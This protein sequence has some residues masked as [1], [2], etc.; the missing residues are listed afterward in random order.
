MSKKIFRVILLVSVITLVASM[1]LFMGAVYGYF[2]EETKAQL[3]NDAV[4]IA[5]AVEQGGDNYLDNLPYTETRVTLVDEDGTVLFDN[6]TDAETMENHEEREEI[7]DALRKGTGESYRISDTIS[8][9]T[10]YYAIKLEDGRVLRVATS[11]YTVGAM[12]IGVLQ[13]VILILILAIVLSLV[14]ASRLSKRIVKPINEINLDNPEK[15]ESYDELAPLLG[16]I[17]RQNKVIKDHISE[18]RQKQDEFTAI[19]ENMSE[20]LVIIDSDFTVLTINASAVRLLGAEEYYENNEAVNVLSLNRSDEFSTAVEEAVAGK[21]TNAVMKIG[22]DMCYEI[23]ANP[24]RHDEEICGAVILILDVTEKQKRE[25]L[26]REFTSNVSHELRTPLT[27]ISGVAEIMMNGI[28]K[29]ED[30]KNFASNIYDEAGRLIVL[31]EDIMKLSQMDEK[32]EVLEKAPVD[33]ADAAKSAVNRLSSLAQENGVTLQL[34][35]DSCKIIGVRGLL[36]DM[37]YNLIENAIKYNNPGGRVDVKVELRYGHPV[38][39]VQDNGIGIPRESQGRVFERFYRV[40]KSHSRKIGGTGLGLSIV[41]HGAQLHGASITLNS[42]E[43]VG[44]TVTLRF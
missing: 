16:K 2:D 9:R 21:N 32:P 3:K 27:T 37:I 41:K 38:V 36:E 25:D 28:V 30:V 44:T 20:G 39:I 12:L 29:P 5:E 10:L 6:K 40:D 34:V 31:I 42:K 35:A 11:Q 26:R 15:I 7:A 13:P 17:D 4:L 19:T 33:L 23:I 1:V 24:V 18:L 22:E 14:F 43:N 8:E